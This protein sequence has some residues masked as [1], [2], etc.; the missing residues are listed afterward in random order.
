LSDG[1]EVNT[2]GTDPLAADTDSDGLSDDAEVNTYGTDPLAA[3][4]DGGGV[5][6]GDEILA[7]SDPFKHADDK[8]I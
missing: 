3:D 1:A 6:D 8:L 4:T 7:G 2:H 5:N